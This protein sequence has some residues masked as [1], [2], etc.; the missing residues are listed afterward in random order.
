MIVVHPHTT[1]DTWV[2]KVGVISVIHCNPTSEEIRSIRM[3]GQQLGSARR[4]G[5]I[6]SKYLSRSRSDR[7]MTSMASRCSLFRWMSCRPNVTVPKTPE[8]PNTNREHLWTC[9]AQQFMLDVGSFWK[10]LESVVEEGRTPGISIRSFADCQSPPK[11]LA[12]GVWSLRYLEKTCF[13]A[14]LHWF[15]LGPALRFSSFPWT[16]LIWTH[17]AGPKQSD[18]LSYN[19]PKQS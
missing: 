8:G 9:S 19:M 3:A 10:T 4:I 13:S 11:S 14:S 17:P 12:F 7:D 5:F 18:I 1:R 15:T 16:N 2:Q 6:A